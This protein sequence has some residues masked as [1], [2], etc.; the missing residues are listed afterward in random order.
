[1]KIKQLKDKYINSNPDSILERG[2]LIEALIDN[3]KDIYNILI[4]DETGFLE[5]TSEINLF[6]RIKSSASNNAILK[7]KGYLTKTEFENLSFGIEEILD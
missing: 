6:N 4:K 2:I 5:A 7:L 3:A 1:M